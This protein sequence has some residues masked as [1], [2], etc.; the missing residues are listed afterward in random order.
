KPLVQVAALQCWRTYLKSREVAATQRNKLRHKITGFIKSEDVVIGPQLVQAILD[1]FS[2]LVEVASETAFAAD[3]ATIW[4]NVRQCLTGISPDVQISSANLM[5]AYFSHLASSS[6]QQGEG[7][8]TLPLIGSGGLKLDSTGMRHTCLTCLQSLMASSA[9]TSEALTAQTVRN[10]AF[11]GRCFAAND[12][13]WQEFQGDDIAG[14]DA[15]D[16][17]AEDH[18]DSSA[19]GYLLGQLSY[20]LRQENLAVPARIAALQCQSALVNQLQDTPN[21]Q[22]L[23]RPLY[24]LTEPSLTQPATAAHRELTDKARELMDLLQKKVGSEMYIAALS[25]ARKGAQTKREE[26]RRKRK[27]DAVSAPEKWALAKKRKHES[28][29]ATKKASNA[30]MRGRRRGW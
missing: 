3:S 18:A 12:V 29:K 2:V 25:G 23:L 10:L 11:L 20:I 16:M 26:R 8:A 1:T 24:V 9:Q 5:G 21:L 17:D 4:D 15:E 14:S 22:A 19:L 30:D 7:L 6:T 13:P 27:I 28:Q